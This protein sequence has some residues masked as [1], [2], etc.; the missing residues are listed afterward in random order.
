VTVT[1]SDH[2]PG[3]TRLPADDHLGLADGRAIGVRLWQGQGTPIVALHG[4]LDSSYGWD[5]YATTTRRPVVAFDLPG[6]GR[7]DLPT[8]PRISAYAEDV[9]EAVEAL[10]IGRYAL[11]GHSLGG[12]VATAVAERGPD[13]AETLT[14]IAPTG[15][16]RIRLAEAVSLPGVR[17]V[18]VRTLPLALANQLVV[19][20]AFATMVTRGAA[21][22]A[23]TL[24]R[25]RER[26]GRSAPGARD[27]VAAVVAAGLSERAFHRRRVAYSGSVAVLWG[28]RDRLVPP[29]HARG[30]EAA[31]PQAAV[32]VW[33][34]IG[35]HPQCERFEAFCGFVERACEGAP[36]QC[37]GR[38]SRSRRLRRR[39][40]ASAR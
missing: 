29:G 39:I 14:L 17:E 13:R 18:A 10:G 26:A 20:A 32:E 25:V 7:S 36:D 35:H 22:D 30:V 34:G 27:A 37:A 12:A 8:R 11:V 1:A 21:M 9:I 2:R 15:F 40:T 38:P 23:G 31:L 19:R 3:L 28:D 6:F 5:P 24:T 4:L 16:G 33:E